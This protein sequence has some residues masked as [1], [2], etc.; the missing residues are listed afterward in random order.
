MQ[1]CGYFD[2]GQAYM[3]A[4]PLEQSGMYITPE[5]YLAQEVESEKRYEYLDGKTYLMAGASY[6]HNVITGNVSALFNV[7]LEDAACASFSSDMRLQVKAHNLYTYP[8][9]MVTCGEIEFATGRNDTALNPAVIVEVLS[10]S[11][12]TYDRTTKFEMYRDIPSFQE[13]ILIDQSR[14]YVEHYRHLETGQW[15]LTVYVHLDSV[16]V[17]EAI[18]VKLP[19]RRVYH[20]VDWVR[21][22]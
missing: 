19:L 20:K 3:M 2:S 18:K 16:L 11:T 17:V 21:E 10:K 12:Q 6:N 7:G 9:V 15:V 1:R 8:D 14:V 13:Y 4:L 22:G 5:E